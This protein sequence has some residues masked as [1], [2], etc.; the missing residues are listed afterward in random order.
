MFDW[1]GNPCGGPYRDI[2]HIMKSYYGVTD[3]TGKKSII[4]FYGKIFI[5][6][7]DGYD[8]VV[9]TD[10]LEKIVEMFGLYSKNGKWGFFT[11]GGDVSKPLY[12]NIDS[13]E[14]K[15]DGNYMAYVSIGDRYGYATPDVDFE[16]FPERNV[17]NDNEDC[18]EDLPF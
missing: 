16:P 10:D 3:E 1:D 13:V 9:Y 5:D 2:L 14:I 12:D 6:D 18:D 8:E 17:D 11:P 7:I 4:D 15:E